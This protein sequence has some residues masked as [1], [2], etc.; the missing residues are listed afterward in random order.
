M[1]SNSPGTH[2][3]LASFTV[4]T[5]QRRFE[6]TSLAVFAVCR[7]AMSLTSRLTHQ[8]DQHVT[9]TDE[10]TAKLAGIGHRV[11]A[12]RRAVL[13]AMSASQ[14]PFTIEEIC[15][16]APG[17]GRATVFRTVKLLQESEVLCR[18]LLEDGS[19]RYQLSR[20]GHHHHLVCSY[21]GSVQEFAEPRL[22]ALIQQVARDNRFNLEGHSLDL[23][24]QCATCARRLTT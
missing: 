16:A 4:W 10:T 8:Y 2:G 20:S 12:T 1:S 21:C 13:D 6:A 5:S 19:I 7:R 11:T 18:V 14:R 9:A 23:Y 17:V 24:G 3:G 15:E 22:D